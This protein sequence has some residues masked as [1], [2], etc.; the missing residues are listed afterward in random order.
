MQ[1]DAIETFIVRTYSQPLARRPLCSRGIE[2]LERMLG[3]AT[4]QVNDAGLD[5]GKYALEHYPVGRT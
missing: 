3:I 5:G 2:V 4:S 1:K